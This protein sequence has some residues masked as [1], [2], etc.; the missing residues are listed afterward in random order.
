MV[1][2]VK[3]PPWI[4]DKMEMRF[5]FN[6]EYNPNWSLWLSAR[7]VMIKKSSSRFQHKKQGTMSTKIETANCNK[8][9]NQIYFDLLR[10]ACVSDNSSYISVDLKTAIETINH[11]PEYAKVHQ[12][13]I[14]LLNAK[15]HKLNIFDDLSKTCQK[16]LTF[17]TQQG[18]VTE[19]AKKSQLTD[20]FNVLVKKNIPF[21]ILKGAAFAN[22]LYSNEAPRISNDLDILIKKEH[23]QSAVLAISTIMVYKK[24]SG[25]VFD[26]LCE[27]SFRPKS[28][29][30]AALDLHVSLSYP[31]LFTINEH[32]LWKSSVPHPEY[33]SENIRLLSAEQALVHQAIHAFVDMNFCKY[34]LVDSHEI[35]NTLQP[36][37]NKAMTI[38]KEWGAST[39]L[40][41]LLTYCEKVMNSN[42][43]KK[44]LKKSKPNSL[45]RFSAYKLLNSSYSQPVGEKKTLRYRLNQILSQFIFTGSIT[46]PLALQWL[47]VKSFIFS[48]R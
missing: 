47:F 45:I 6:L 27:I 24:K 9:V 37:I 38:A 17:M 32:A 19:L 20:I 18:I 10:L 41:I 14:P 30:G 35:I 8:K 44:I 13:I 3:K 39:P 23:W 11:L 36:D 26:D 16:L 1:V 15:A 29:I 42:F 48:D 31:L 43:D 7:W 21:I 22:V 25:Q 33:G 28:N 34:N 4:V 12:R 5:Q 46:R 40:Y 2:A